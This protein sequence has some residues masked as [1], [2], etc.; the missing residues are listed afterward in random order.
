MM[1]ARCLTI[2]CPHLTLSIAD[3][4]HGFQSK[5]SPWVRS[6]KLNLTTCQSTRLRRLCSGACARGRA[7]SSDGT[8]GIHVAGT[9]SALGT[10]CPTQAHRELKQ[11]DAARFTPNRL[12]SPV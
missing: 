12:V 8:V 3:L 6:G 5:S 11:E 4:V 9:D 2:G 7:P 10:A 1:H